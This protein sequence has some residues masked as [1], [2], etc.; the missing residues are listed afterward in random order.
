VQLDE[1]FV[2][3]LLDD[4]G[5]DLGVQAG[6]ASVDVM[7]DGAGELGLQS[8]PPLLYEAFEP[9]SPKVYFRRGRTAFREAQQ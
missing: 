6:L 8:L 5:D 9:L 4:A 7:A 1:W 2:M 3:P